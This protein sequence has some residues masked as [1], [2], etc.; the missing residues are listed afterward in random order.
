MSA[1]ACP[2]CGQRRGKRFCPAKGASICSVC[3]GSK[4]LVEIA[5]PSDCAYLT[6]AHAPAWEGRERDRRQDM[7][8][9]APHI[10]GLGQDDAA[11]FFYLLAGMVR[12]S[13]KHRD[14]DDVHWQQ[15]VAALAKTLETRESGLVYEHAAEGFRAQE[16]V[17]EMREVIEPPGG[18]GPVAPDPMLRA[19]LAAIGQALA[20]TIQ[21]GA[22]A[23]EFLATATRLTAKLVEHGEPR[24]AETKP[25]LIEP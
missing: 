10:E 14:A 16:L 18:Q 8:R 2:L 21:E 11:V 6:G 1:P 7:M 19:A 3:C 5:C 23:K 25:T 17:R 12:V 13:A 20:R 15:A 24:P 22:G 9:I 4:R